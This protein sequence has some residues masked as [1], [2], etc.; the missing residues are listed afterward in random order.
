MDYRALVAAVLEENRQVLDA[1][2]PQE[3][4]GF[5]EEILRAKTVHL[6]G[7]G[8]MQLSVRGFAMRLKHMGFDTYVVY[9]TT[10]PRIG[11]GDL[12]IGHCA[13]TNVEF[14]RHPFS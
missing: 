11:A 12:L 1:V 3:I 5:I 7:M 14:E 8:R 2:N 13:V 4:E 9:D 6:Y 10:S